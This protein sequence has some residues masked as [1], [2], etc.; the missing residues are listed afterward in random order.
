MSIQEVS[1]RLVDAVMKND[2]EAAR[3]C[4]RAGASPDVFLNTSEGDFQQCSPL[5]IASIKN[6]ATMIDLLLMYDA[7]VNW[8]NRYGATA[9]I[10]AAEGKKANAA[11]AL[12]AKGADPNL[13]KNWGG[14]PLHWAARHG[15][16]KLC[17]LLLR[18]GADASIKNEKGQTAGGWAEKDGHKALA[19]YLDHA[20]NSWEKNPGNENSIV[21]RTLPAPDTGVTYIFNFSAM[22]MSKLTKDFES[23]KLT[24]AEMAFSDP[25]AEKDVITA[26]AKKFKEL[27][28]KLNEALFSRSLHTVTPF[29]HVPRY[30][31]SINRRKPS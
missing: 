3:D 17:K 8:M 14:T 1:G 19:N 24:T 7:D 28:G 6:N 26:A 20:A 9:L 13:T 5:M 23:G 12:L 2:V 29:S 15:E 4:L 16:T 27:G 30:R 25:A 11:E 31:R 18:F 22:T 10:Y 21:H